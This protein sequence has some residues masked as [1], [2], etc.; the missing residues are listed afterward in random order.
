MVQEEPGD[1]REAFSASLQGTSVHLLQSDPLLRK[2]FG[3]VYMEGA[4]FLE[5][6]KEA[7]V[8]EGRSV[9]LICLLFFV[10]VLCD[11]E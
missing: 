2:T 8:F 11:L 7:P 4:T 5:K 1:R 6:G 9:S 10:R 3:G